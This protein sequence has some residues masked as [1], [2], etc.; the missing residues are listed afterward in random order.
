MYHNLQRLNLPPLQSPHIERGADNV[1]R[2]F[3]PLRN[4][5]VALTPEEWVRQH[6]TSW[7]IHHRG[8]PASLMGNEVS[9]TLNGMSRRCDTVLFT[10]QGLLPQMIIEYKAPKIEITQRVFDQIAR[11]NMVLR[12]PYL[13]VSNG[14]SHYCLHIDYEAGKSRFLRDVPAYDELQ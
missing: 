10:R 12:A 5:P 6:F 9:L 7:L 11:Y 3:D 8:Y 1:T 13:A 2:I 14:L 4:K